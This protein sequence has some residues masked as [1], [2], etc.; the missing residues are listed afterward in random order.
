MI[1]PRKT[2]AFFGSLLIAIFFWVF[3]SFPVTA[4]FILEA[5]HL[6]IRTVGSKMPP[7]SKQAGSWKIWSNGEIS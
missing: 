7:G 1:L 5:P 3:F 2:P 6:S 4:A